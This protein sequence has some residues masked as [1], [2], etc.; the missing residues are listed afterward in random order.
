MLFVLAVSGKGH[1]VREFGG[2]GEACCEAAWGEGVGGGRG[3]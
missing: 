2:V 1:G 3:C